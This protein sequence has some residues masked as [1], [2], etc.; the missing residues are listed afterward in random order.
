MI[1]TRTARVIAFLCVALGILS[2][3]AGL[4][5]LTQLD[6]ETGQSFGLPVGPKVPLLAQ[7]AQILFA[8]LVLGVLSEISA[9]LSRPQMM[10]NRKD[11]PDR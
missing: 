6:G 9:H 3:G 5:I 1:F 2:I 11:D 7:G 10:P 8:G 4:T